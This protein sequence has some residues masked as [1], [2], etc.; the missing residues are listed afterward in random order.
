M[1]G[2][3][4][5]RSPPGALPLVSLPLSLVHTH[6]HSLSLSLR[7]YLGGARYPSS[8]G[9]DNVLG[10][11]RED[12]R[13]QVGS[14]GHCGWRA[15]PGASPLAALPISLFDAHTHSLSLS[16]THTH[17]HTLSLSLSLSLS[18]LGRYLGGA[19]YPGSNAPHHVLA[20]TRSTL[21]RG[22]SPIQNN[23]PVGPYSRPMPRALQ[24]C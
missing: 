3:S 10:Q 2:H 12:N 11:T 9:P 19:R 14:C 21:Y 15:R 6:T 4:G 1:L 18:S 16:Y 20:P 22:A 7:R 5:W 17:T 24:S 8:N 23:S 13:R